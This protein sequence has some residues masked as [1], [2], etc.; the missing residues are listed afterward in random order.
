MTDS[1]AVPLCPEEGTHQENCPVIIYL[2]LAIYTL[3]PKRGGQTQ[4]QQAPVLSVMVC[5]LTEELFFKWKKRGLQ[6]A[7]MS[8][9]QKMR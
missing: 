1:A 7:W 2:A 3:M 8:E 9:K 4:W 5:A 6:D